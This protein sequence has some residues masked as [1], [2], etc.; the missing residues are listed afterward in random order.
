VQHGSRFNLTSQGY[1]A[2]GVSFKGL[3]EN[4]ALTPELTPHESRPGLS[5]E[6]A[7]LN[8]ATFR[9][10]ERPHGDL[11]YREYC[12]NAHRLLTEEIAM[13]RKF[14]SS[15]RSPV[16]H[17]CFHQ[18]HPGFSIIRLRLSRDTATKLDR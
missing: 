7:K 8:G 11:R 5:K 4:V 16:K 12:K 15:N 9:Y 6:N 3:A 13:R 18:V 10:W 1:F 17:A 14:R 2:I